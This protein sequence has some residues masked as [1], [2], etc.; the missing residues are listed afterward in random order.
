MGRWA[1]SSRETV[2][3]C[4][5]LSV[6]ELNQKQVLSGHISAKVSWGTVW[7]AAEQSIGIEVITTGDPDYAGSVQLKYKL[8]HS[9]TG[10][11]EILDYI[12]GLE[13]TSCRFGGIR[14]WFVCPLM[15]GADACDERVGKLYLPPNGKYFGCRKC[16]NLT[17]RSQKE[18]KPK[19]SKAAL[20]WLHDRL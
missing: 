17:Y 16:Y 18:R 2:E 12:V 15:R 5:A 7:G 20:R 4:R 9:S 3:D 10:D 13:A 11:S 1:W 14:Y 6:F 19:L 8:T